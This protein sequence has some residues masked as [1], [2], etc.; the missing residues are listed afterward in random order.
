MFTQTTKIYQPLITVVA[1]HPHHK[2]HLLP[3]IVLP[4]SNS[5]PP[6]NIPF[7]KRFLLPLHT[8]SLPLLRG[9]I[10]SKQP[11]KFDLSSNQKSP[12]KVISL[13]RLYTAI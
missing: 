9:C 13:S 4:T 11:I 1:L 12:P 6:Q 5:S 8:P 10:N 2:K 3:K 7:S